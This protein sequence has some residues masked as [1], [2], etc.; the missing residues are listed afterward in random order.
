MLI[1]DRLFSSLSSCLSGSSIH[2][3]Q[4]VRADAS[5]ATRHTYLEVL[6]VPADGTG[7][8]AEKR[9]FGMSRVSSS[10]IILQR[11]SARG[12]IPKIDGGEVSFFQTS[13]SLHIIRSPR[14]RGRALPGRSSSI[15]LALGTSRKEY[16][17]VVADS[18]ASLWA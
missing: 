15:R 1:F 3:L 14:R 10:Q 8:A 4:V 6:I 9:N 11:G 16:I 7:A 12:Q 2:A 13:L 18:F 5:A 17:A